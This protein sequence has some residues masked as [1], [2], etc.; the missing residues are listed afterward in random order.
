MEVGRK[1]NAFDSNC[2]SNPVCGCSRCSGRP[3]PTWSAPL[4]LSC[5]WSPYALHSFPPEPEP[6]PCWAMA[7][8]AACSKGNP[9][10]P[11]AH[12]LLHSPASPQDDPSCALPPP[13]LAH[14]LFFFLLCALPL[15]NLGVS[16]IAI[17]IAAFLMAFR[18]PPCIPVC[19][20]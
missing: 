19:V 6:L 9:T 11:V 2:S 17:N 13:R 1:R 5:V 20:W 10:L 12:S 15:Q 16:L 4:P 7:Y 18:T 14:R 3:I 8:I